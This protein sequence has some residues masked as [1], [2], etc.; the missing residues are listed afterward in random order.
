MKRLYSIN[1]LFL[2]KD[3]HQEFCEEV[4]TTNAKRVKIALVILFIADII[5]V[6]L[7]VKVFKSLYENQ[8]GYR[9]VFY[10]DVLLLFVAPLYVVLITKINKKY[11]KNLGR[12]IVVF[13]L[14]WSTFLSINAQ[15]THGQISAYI[16]GIFCVASIIIINPYESL[17][18][19]LLQYIFFVIGTLRVNIGW[20]PTTSHIVNA[21]ILTILAIA[22]AN[23]NYGYHLRNFKNKKLIM[24][25][26]EE[27]NNLYNISEANLNKRTQ[28]LMESNQR[29]IKEINEKHKI[30]LEVIRTELLI[31]EKQKLLTEK[32]E[33]EK[34]RTAFLLIYHMNLEH[35]SL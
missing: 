7:D 28:E 16:L 29:L 5:L 23:I 31:E 13:L 11:H 22:I 15:L 14:T 9:N 1:K 30:E 34:L 10:A 18:L 8:T 35:L 33:Y 21:S 2:P 24:T 27:I 25:K 12:F 32:I 17:F 26:N 3:Y 19:F 4:L 6:C 20:K